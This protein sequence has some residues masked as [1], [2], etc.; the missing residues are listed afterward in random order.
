MLPSVIGG[1]L[2]AVASAFGQNRQNQQNRAEAARN[3]AF[4]ERMSGT[5][6]QRRM[7]DLKAAGINPILAGKFDASTPAGNM[8]TMGNVG[9]A[10]TEGASKG[11]GTAL[12]V[13][14]RKLTEAQIENVEAQTANTNAKTQAMGGL[15]EVGAFMKRIGSWVN[16]NFRPGETRDIVLEKAKQLIST[17][18]HSAEDAQNKLREFAA[19]MRKKDTTDKYDLT[20]RD[21]R[22]PGEFLAEFD[23]R[24]KYKYNRSRSKYRNPKK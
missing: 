4:Q 9:A 21:Y 18:A 5:A 3:R 1:A 22:K 19:N 14:Q 2:G 20:I 17:G 11:A 12:S 10:G 13:W 7:A 8:A 23:K 15:T 24:T 16:E 6:V